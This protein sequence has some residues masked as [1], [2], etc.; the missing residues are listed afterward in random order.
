[1]Y[2]TQICK[3]RTSQPSSIVIVIVITRFT[4]ELDW[5]RVRGKPS[6]NSPE[7]DRSRYQGPSWWWTLDPPKLSVFI[8]E[9]NKINEWKSYQL[10]TELILHVM[11]GMHPF[12][13]QNEISKSVTCNLGAKTNK[14]V[15]QF[16]RIPSWFRNTEKLMNPAIEAIP[17]AETVDTFCLADT[18]WSLHLNRPIYLC[19]ID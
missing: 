18:P 3:I 2:G 13:L 12:F 6:G 11:F 9:M 1:M 4:Y 16:W 17:S 8:E 19:R 14:C 7:H 15:K 10:N 5:L